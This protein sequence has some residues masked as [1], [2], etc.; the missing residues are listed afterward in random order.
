MRF[1]VSSAALRSAITAPFSFVG[2]VPLTSLDRAKVVPRFLLKAPIRVD[3]LDLW[4]DDVPRPR[5]AAF[6]RFA[7]ERRIFPLLLEECLAKVARLRICH[8]LA[9][10]ARQIKCRP[11]AGAKA[12]KV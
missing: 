8:C 12:A 4:T 6:A 5:R 3:C 2:E 7:G 10:P 11:H 1:S 9:F